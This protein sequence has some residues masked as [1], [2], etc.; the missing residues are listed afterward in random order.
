MLSMTNTPDDVAVSGVTCGR[1]TNFKSQSH[2][3]ACPRGLAVYGAKTTDR[4][5]CRDGHVKSAT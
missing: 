1:S 3:E 4:R 2:R 5:F